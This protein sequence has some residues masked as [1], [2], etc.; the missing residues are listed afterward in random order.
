MPSE[1][2]IQE[3]PLEQPSNGLVSD[4]V[5]AVSIAALEISTA[6]SLAVLIFAGDL[7]GGVSRASVA[8][9]FGSTVVLLAVASRTTFRTII[10][11]SQDT[12]AVVMAAIAA[13]IAAEAAPDQ[14]LPTVFVAIALAGL[15]S[16]ALLI[17]V[18]RARLGEAARSIPFTVISGFMAGT[19]WILSRGGVEVMTG[20]V[21]HFADI[22]DLFGWDLAK[23][24]LPGV[25]LATFVAVSLQ[26]NLPSIVVGLAMLVTAVAIHLIGQFGW[27]FSALEDNGWLIGPFPESARWTPVGPTD[28]RD[29]DWGVLVRQAFPLVG[30]AAVA[31]IGMILNVTG[32][33]VACDDDPDVD[34]E[35]VVAGAGN[36]I[37]SLLGGLVGYHAFGLTMVAHRLKTRGFR[38]PLLVGGLT[39]VIVLFGSSIVAVMPRAVAGGLLMA[40]GVGLLLDWVKQVTRGLNRL[41]A[42]LSTAVLLVIIAFGVL[43]GIVAGVLAAAILFVFQY[44]QVSP[45]RTVRDLSVA[46]SNVDRTSVE[47]EVLRERSSEA[48][49]I[50]LSGYLFFGS[51]RQIGE[52]I[53]ELISNESLRFLV[54]DF[55]RVTGVDASVIAGLEA[56][57]RRANRSGVS[58]IWSNIGDE[59]VA[60]F[61]A[62]GAIDRQYASDLDHGLEL[63]ENH[64]LVP[65]DTSGVDIDR[66]WIEEIRAFGEELQLEADELLI[67]STDVT[68]RMFV[69]VEGSLTAW[70]H[71]QGGRRIRYRQVGPGSL[72]GEV[73]FTTGAPRTA[74]VI[75]DTPCTVIA[76]DPAD[77]AAMS[78]NASEVAARTHQV[79]AERLAERLDHTSRTVRELNS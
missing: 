12:T 35:L 68:R 63:V 53:R 9:M 39:L 48:N 6:V 77:V 7:S 55:R 33:E 3:G 78:G 2:S 37:S 15:L 21:T 45:V 62:G 42:L 47:R 40:A 73:S 59:L 43:P 25:A 26:R 24:W 1:T 32:L 27:S 34:H 19:G 54:L 60:E 74:V 14:R 13:T 66:E 58:L 22:G 51:V 52:V 31:L 16:S 70:G 79:I 5:A 67:D 41:D 11:G 36:T 72:L 75:A 17:L 64:F 61:D 29:A 4:L 57:E 20:E 44:S 76:L 23:L 65:Y 56:L 69:V 49:A 46:Q 71:T 28:V 50:E 18:G 38:V 8:F 10:A 30:L